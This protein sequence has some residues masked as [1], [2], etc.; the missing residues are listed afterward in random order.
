M[1]LKEVELKF[2]TAEETIMN[3]ENEIVDYKN[4]SK[5]S[6]GDKGIKVVFPK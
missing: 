4:A 1:Q 5:L 6:Y 2:R 3:L